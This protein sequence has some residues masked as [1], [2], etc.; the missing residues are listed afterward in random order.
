MKKEINENCKFNL[1]LKKSITL[2]MKLSIRFRHEAY[3]VLLT[4]K[5]QRKF[6]I[7]F[8]DFFEAY[9]YFYVL[10]IPK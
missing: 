2:D 7:F 3:K 1:L 10:K 5:Q 9:I 4:V 8:R 6:S